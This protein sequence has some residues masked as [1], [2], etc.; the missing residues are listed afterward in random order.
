MLVVACYGRLLMLLY[1]VAGP[2]HVRKRCRICVVPGQKHFVFERPT[3]CWLAKSLRGQKTTNIRILLLG[4]KGPYPLILHATGWL[5][6]ILSRVLVMLA[7]S[8][9]ALG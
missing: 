8:W 1:T 3:R 4:Y 2:C 9:S 7:D 5:K 6:C